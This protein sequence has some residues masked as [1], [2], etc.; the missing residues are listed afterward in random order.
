MIFNVA[1]I[2]KFILAKEIHRKASLF[3]V[4]H[5]LWMLLSENSDSHDFT[6]ALT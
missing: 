2:N 3:Y 5:S 4:K 1:P 6:G